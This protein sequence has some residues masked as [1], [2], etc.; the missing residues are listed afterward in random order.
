MK[1]EDLPART[2]AVLSSFAI[3]LIFL[4]YETPT[5]SAQVLYGSVVGTVT[6]QTGAVI[7]SATVKMTNTSTGLVRQATADS[8]GNYSMTNLQEGDYDLSVS[9]AGFIPLTQKGVS[10]RINNVTHVD[11]RLKVGGVT[12]SVTVDASAAQLQT[13]KTDVNTNLESK[14]IENLPLSGY[15]NFQSLVNFVPGATPGRFQNAVIDTPQRDLSTNVNGQE[16]GAN[17]TRVDGA[18][19][20]LVTMPHH[21][22]YVPPVESIQEVSI[23]TNNFDAEQGITG[24]AAV[25]VST[26]SG[27]NEFH[28][29]AFAMHANNATRAFLWDENRAGV[30]KKP[31]GI[32]NI[33]GGSIGGPIKKNKLFFFADWEGTFERVGRSNLFS[34]PTD[35]FRSGDFSRTLGPQ[36]LDAG[37][38]PI[39]VPTTEGGSVPLQAGMI[40][41][42]FTGNADGTE[43][44]VFSSGGRLNVIPALRLNPALMRLLALVPHANQAGDLNNYFNLG[45]QRLNRNNV[46]AKV[47]WNRNEKNQVWFKYSV[48]TALVN[49]EFGLGEAGGECLCDGGVGAGHTL[50]QLATIGQT[51]TLSPTFVIDGT[52]GWTRFGQNVQSPDLGT[53]FGSEVLGIPGTNGPD[54]RESGMP[55]FSLTDYSSLGNTEGWNPLFRNDQ[56]FTF[57]TNASWM[58][59]QHEIRFGFDFLHH[60]MNHWQPELGSGP[61]GAFTFDPGV[62]AL[63]PAAIKARV[64]FRGADPSFENSWNSLA[65]FLLGTPTGAGKSSQFIKMDSQENVYGLYLRD[66]WRA[67]PKLT[68]N[69][70]LRWELY[71]NRTRSAGLGIESYDPTTNEVL[72]GGRGDVPRDNGVGFSKRLLAPRVGFAYQVGNSTVI[73]SGYGLTYHSHPW[74]AQ[75]LRGWFPLTIAAEFS[76]ANG[77]QPVTTDPNYVAG[78]IPNQPLGSGVGILPICCP[79]LGAGRIPL[80]PANEMG[81]PVANRQLH[82]GYIQS[83]NFIIET[84]LPGEL[85]TSVGYVGT[86]SVNG[87]AFLDLNA[88]QIPGSGNDGRPLFAQFG[89]TATTREWDGRT[90][91]TYHSLQASVNRRL[92]GG[93]FLKAS[94]TYSHAIDQADYSDWTEFRWNAPSVFAR[95]RA[96]SSNNIPQ[97]FQFGTVYE[98][99]FGG[100]KRWAQGG[101]AGALLGGWQLNGIFSAYQGRPYT[102]TA[103]GSTLNMPGNQQT[104]DQIKSAVNKLGLVGDD[105]TWFDTTAFA[106][107]TDVRFG[108]V[109]RNTLSGPGVVNLDLGLFR[110]FKLTERFNLQFRV[111]SFNVSNTPHFSNPT[112]DI[113]SSNFGKILSTQSADAMG[114]SREFRFALRLGF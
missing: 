74:G 25:T 57:N 62:T 21:M 15:R 56:S 108:N 71:P 5:A 39:S 84:K 35:D 78:G 99:P 96:T 113:N 6:E 30:S 69:L 11:V 107:P 45:T 51:Y 2:V 46:D 59:G 97:I 3:S 92:T 76:G 91:S 40:F 43:R 32:R 104:P 101:V 54:R 52:L 19:N 36:I 37:G 27:T 42:P 75:A 26:K 85:V 88:S 38:N 28:G 70:G 61:R 109:G 82:R 102:L 114:R 77:F 86:A 55:A 31:K 14:A 41:D 24:G 4:C 110:V 112:A 83:W 47:N 90:H 72:I 106:R 87:F 67:T 1:R 63:N 81:Y 8:A 60:L 23:S 89:R 53:N 44:A 9:A 18:A 22:V 12:E 94:Y 93:L 111:E 73:R 29:S 34:V 10:V 65:G 7:P 58:K 33:D 13:T 64:G 79:D 68:L 80:P 103:S 66:R 95:N 50:V 16:R 48:M 105:G 17:N 20:I 49:G 100:G 98:L